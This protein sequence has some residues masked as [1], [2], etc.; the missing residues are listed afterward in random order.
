VILERSNPEPLECAGVEVRFGSLRAVAGADLSV[1]AS[2]IVAL[3]GRSG[4]GKTTLLRAIAGFERVTAGEIRIGGAMVESPSKSVPAHKRSVGLVFQDYA[5]FPNRTVAG[6]ISYGLGHGSSGRV[7]ELLRLAHLEG[8]GGRY[9]HQLSGG[10]QQRVAVLRSVAPRPR[11][12]LLDEPFSNLDASLRIEMREE[13]VHILRAEGTTAVLVTHDRADAMAAADRI[14]V[15][16]AG[17]IIEVAAPSALYHA[18][19]TIIGAGYAGDA[20]FVRGLARGD[21]AETVLGTVRLLNAMEGECQVLV[22]PEWIARHVAGTPLRVVTSRFE[23]AQARVTLEAP[24]GTR[25]FAIVPSWDAV[26]AGDDFDASV[27]MPLPAF[28]V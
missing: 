2:E 7:E 24:D 6:N 3:L 27:A 13:L 9:P 20:Q 14:A 19:A 21:T 1:A 22:R 5:L 12:L 15:M 11:V 26:S 4:S 18:P 17:R 25:L 23:G 8:L 10:Q 28:P 16:E